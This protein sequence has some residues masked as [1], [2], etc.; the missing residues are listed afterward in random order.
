MTEKKGE[1]IGRL[2][3]S[4]NKDIIPNLSSGLYKN[5]SRAVKELISN[6]Y[7]ALATEVKI[8]LDL[9]E[10]KIIIRDN[11]KGMT[12]KEMESKLLNI[13]KKTKTQN[14][15][16]GLGRKRI[17]QFGIGFVAAFPYCETI[18]V[19]SKKEGQPYAYEI[20]INA[21]QYFENEEFNIEGVKKDI[22]CRRYISRLSK[23]KGE[24][25]IL[26]ENIEPRYLKQL[27]QRSSE[28]YTSIKQYG[29][30]DKFKWELSQ[31]LPIQFGKNQPILSKFFEIENRVPMRTWLDG[32][33]LFRNVPVG[34]EVIDKGE[35]SF[36][37]IHVK[38]AFYSTFTSIKPE[39]ARG[40]QL[41]LHD[42]GIGFPTDFDV[43]KLKGRT[44]GKLNWIGGE[45][46]IFEGL[47]SEILIHRDEF[48]F[49]ESV[50]KLHDY[51]RDKLTVLDSK[52]VKQA[53]TDKKIHQIVSSIPDSKEIIKELKDSGI[54]KVGTGSLRVKSKPIVAKKKEKI[55]TISKRLKETVKDKGFEVVTEHKIVSKKDKPITVDKE[56]KRI[57]I[58]DQHPKFIE[59]LTYEH[60]EYL[61]EYSEEDIFQRNPLCIIDTNVNRVVF[62]KNHFIF[63]TRINDDLIKKLAIGL[64]NIQK[65]RDLSKETIDEILQLFTNLF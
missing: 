11:G 52:L 12:D 4:V 19:I 1:E 58:F 39:E 61:V 51:F 6:A 27:K 56:R 41:R 22:P 28:G 45:I 33:E 35:K 7:D 2:S 47:D 63:E 62:N 8:N 25:L 31:Y 50:S 21:K 48:S 24:T 13:G 44:L 9:K 42:V 64:F 15:D 16:I 10:N 55:S 29:G 17:G 46:N 40:L 37:N 26:L 43:V 53:L 32:I 30:Y 57:V 36:G 59:K 23:D 3:I 20:E 38:Y 5:F 60:V 65:R 49:T 54:V 14:R 34:A 18:R